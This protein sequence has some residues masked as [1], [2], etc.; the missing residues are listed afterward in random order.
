MPAIDRLRKLL[1]PKPRMRKWDQ[2]TNNLPWTDRPDAMEEIARRE[3]A[4]KLSAEDAALARKWVK[5]GYVVL[6]GVA[7]SDTVDGINREMDALWTDDTPVN[8]LKLNDV[9]LKEGENP[10]L[11]IE[12]SEIVKL[13]AA[14][15][16]AI[17]NRG[18]WRTHGFHFHSKPAERLFRNE[19]MKHVVSM[20][21]GVPTDPTFS[22]NFHWGSQHIM[23]QDMMV[24]HVHPRNYLIGGWVALEDVSPDCGPLVYCPGSHVEPVYHEYDNYPQTNL[25]TSDQ[26]RRDRY[27]AHLR[28]VAKKYERRQFLPKKGDALLWHAMLLHG[29]DEIRNRALTRRSFVI[30]YVPQGMDKTGEVVGP[31]MW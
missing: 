8:G 16:L 31:F 14:E 2:S 20:L 25:R 28:E 11:A 27:E 23:H 1:K 7:E 18:K 22:I 24:F 13:P 4:G 30:H 5:D 19:R 9:F 6:E 10:T 29:G 3:K 21:L 17:K 15:R 12:H 26:A